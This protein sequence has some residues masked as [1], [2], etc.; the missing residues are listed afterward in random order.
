MPKS[1]KP[2]RQGSETESAEVLQLTPKLRSTGS[3]RLL[4]QRIVFDGATADTAAEVAAPEPSEA[5]SSSNDPTTADVIA[6]L[7]SAPVNP[8][9]AANV[10]IFIDA[11]VSDADLLAAAVS[12]DGQVIMLA[13][14]SDGLEQVPDSA[15]F[16]MP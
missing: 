4:E 11:N 9:T 10:L 12:N 6:A 13:P 14:D 15:F 7:A 3:Y 16:H 2:G 5:P 1:G 8:E